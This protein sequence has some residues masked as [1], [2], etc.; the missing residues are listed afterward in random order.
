MSHRKAN[1]AALNTLPFA[2]NASWDTSRACLPDTRI[3]LLEEIWEWITDDHKSAKIFWIVD[4]AGVGKT[5]LA[6][7]VGQR[8]HAEGVFVFSFFFDREV[9]GRN[10]AHKLFSTIARGLAK[11]DQG[12]AKHICKAIEHD[13][14]FATTA[15]VSRQFDELILRPSQRYSGTSPI[16]IIIDGLDEGY[17]ADL[18]AILRDKVRNLPRTFRIFLTSRAEEDIIFYLSHAAHIRSCTMNIH[19]RTNQEDVALYV[20]H[21]LQDIAAR[22]GLP[23]DWPGKQLLAEFV[24]KADGLFIWAATVSDFLAR[25]LDPTKYLKRLL[26]KRDASELPEEA[27]MDLL[28]STIISIQKSRLFDMN[29]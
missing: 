3:A 18:L 4:V 9:A 13:P 21:R 29:P 5:A 22:K 16:V 28:Y 6:H 2:E 1:S 20:K 26:S 14:D 27:R 24:Q 7:S 17:D 19:E 11:I 12:V 15:S 23:K 25:V 8:C 10:S